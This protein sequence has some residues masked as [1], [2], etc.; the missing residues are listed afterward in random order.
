M[1]LQPEPRG[2]RRDRA[3]DAPHAHDAERFAGDAVAEH[4]GRTPPRPRRLADRA[5]AVGEAARGPQNERHRGVRRI[6]GQHA[7]RVADEDAPRARRCQIDVVGAHAEI[8]DQRE[9][10]ARAR[11]QR[12]VDRVRNGGHEHIG[13]GRR[14]REFGAGE[15]PVVV[16][17][18]GVEQIAHPRLHRRRQAIG[19]GDLG[20]ARAIS[21]GQGM[22][23]AASLLKPE[24]PALRRLR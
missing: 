24:L 6:V 18:H 14:A 17:Q 21:H 9:P 13:V 19:D 12:T 16:A 15:R 23:H 2:A 20:A 4:R 1:H 7:G 3:A 5:L 8:G 22:S 11:D 10:F